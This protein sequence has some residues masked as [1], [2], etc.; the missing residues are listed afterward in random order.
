[1]GSSEASF[2]RGFALTLLTAD[3]ALASAA[4][5]AGVDRIGVDVE[6]LG[7]RER[8]GAIHDARISEHRLEDLAVLAPHVRRAQLFCRIDPPH[9]GTA[10]QVERALELGA[11]VIMLP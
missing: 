9:D 6:R 4:D 3:P 8:Q 1:M 7:K 11:G 2:G 10:R 5:A